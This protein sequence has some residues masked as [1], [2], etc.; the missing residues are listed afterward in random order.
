MEESKWKRR[1]YF[2]KKEFQ[3]KIIVHFVTLVILGSLVS[4]V[5]LYYF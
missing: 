2:I 3:T 1:T 4:G 5:L